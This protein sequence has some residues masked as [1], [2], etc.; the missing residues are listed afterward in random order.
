[1]AYLNEQGKSSPDPSDVPEKEFSRMLTLSTM[2]RVKYYRMLNIRVHANANEK[3]KSELK[4]LMIQERED[5]EE[6][7]NHIRYGIGRCSLFPRIRNTSI[8]KWKN[9]RYIYQQLYKQL[10]LK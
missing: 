1:M 10:Q 6:E 5:E 7:S 8:D 9:M 4:S 3:A 2:Q